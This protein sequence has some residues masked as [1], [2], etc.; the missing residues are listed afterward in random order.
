M[1][2]QE[3]CTIESDPGLFTELISDF[4]AKDLQ[5]E[6]IFDLSQDIADSHG[7][8]FLFKWRR[9]DDP[10]MVLDPEN[11][12][13][14]FFAKQVITNACAT[15]AI[16]SVLLNASG[17][18]VDLGT[19]MTDFKNFCMGFD[20][21][22]RGLAI[23]NSDSIRV[24][25]NSFARSDSFFLEESK[26]KSEKGDAHHFI[27]YV[28]HEGN[29]Y[30]LDGLK[31]GP[32]HLGSFDSG[33]DWLSVARPAVEARMARYSESET[34][35][36]LMSIGK[37]MLSRLDMQMSSMRQQLESLESAGG[38]DVAAVQQCRNNL[39]EITFQMA[40]ERLKLKSQKEENAL[41]RH[42]F[43]PL[44]TGLL[45]HLSR[46]GAL[47]QLRESAKERSETS[48]RNRAANKK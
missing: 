42:N 47:P 5:V 41:R 7:L 43:I 16:L 15:Q 6:E 30:E 1:A 18:S 13:G 25:H 29:V 37:S 44:I 26:A 39:D 10:R 40:E 33:T 32:I 21:E 45:K 11:V 2:S 28:P 22:S 8:I 27:A 12:P 9:E 14:L 4:G 36:A 23:S 3:W 35:F 38:A 34:H 19:E 46:K 20:A 17:E 24:A 48:R 31:A